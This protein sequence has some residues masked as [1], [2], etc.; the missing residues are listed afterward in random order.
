MLA[1]HARSEPLDAWIAG[2]VARHRAVYSGVFEYQ[3]RS[4]FRDA[5][6]L[7]DS[8]GTT[9]F[10]F[11]ERSWLVRRSHPSTIDV[12]HDNVHLEIRYQEHSGTGVVPSVWIHPPREI[13]A[14][15]HQIPRFAGTFWY[16][17]TAAFIE[18]HAK[19]CR[20]LGRSEGN[21]ESE[22]GIIDCNVSSREVGAFGVIT[23]ELRQGGTIRM[24][25]GPSLGFA[26]TRIEYLGVDGRI[27]IDF[28]SSDFRQVG[29]TLFCPTE[30]KRRTF[31]A[32]G[33]EGFFVEYSFT[34][35]QRVNEAIPA[36]E[37]VVEFPKG[38]YVNDVRPGANG[39]VYVVGESIVHPPIPL[40]EGLDVGRRVHSR[41]WL[42][43][44]GL[45]LVVALGVLFLIQACTSARRYR[46]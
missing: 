28:T 42:A 27:A 37:F 43:A 33:T 21:G 30:C 46:G 17:A 20:W 44:A 8:V 25:T 19:D 10:K 7:I 38:T 39:A 2:V 9:E 12:T 15:G 4:G 40:P 34:A 14:P 6:R 5:G 45:G 23:E 35:M 13:D 18:T 24:H 41:G 29:P 36:G 16:P 3:R 32:D 26:L 31:R 11:F 22:L 1:G